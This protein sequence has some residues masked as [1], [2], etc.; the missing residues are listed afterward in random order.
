MKKTLRTTITFLLIPSLIFAQIPQYKTSEP[1]VKQTDLARLWNAL[2]TEVGQQIVF[3][4]ETT[5]GSIDLEH[6]KAFTTAKGEVAFVPIKSLRGVLA[7]LC[8]RQ[9]QDGAEYLFLI[10]YNTTQKGVAFTFPSGRMYVMKPGGVTESINPDFQFQEHDNLNKRISINANDIIDSLCSPVTTILQLLISLIFNPCSWVVP[11][12]G[13][14]CF[15]LTWIAI[16]YVRLLLITNAYSYQ[17]TN[18]EM[19]SILFAVYYYGCVLAMLPT[20]T[21]T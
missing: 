11:G 5:V 13:Y 20:N 18:L 10:A 19:I 14:F 7:A 4:I 16:G 12:S 15:I 3:Y 1:S 2:N 21:N 9:L 6:A 17:N 8:Y